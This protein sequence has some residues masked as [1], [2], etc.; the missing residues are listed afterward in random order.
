MSIKLYV[1]AD[2]HPT[3]EMSEKSYC[4]RTEFRDYTPEAGYDWSMFEK[5]KNLAKSLILSGAENVT[6]TQQ[7]SQCRGEM[8]FSSISFA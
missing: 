5:A 6:I 4:D 7:D 8:E 3:G 1:E 2:I